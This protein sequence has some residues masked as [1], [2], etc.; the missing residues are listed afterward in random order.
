[1]SSINLVHAFLTAILVTKQK[2]MR[3]ASRCLSWLAHNISESAGG[4]ESCG[5]FVEG[6][7]GSSR[8]TVTPALVIADAAWGLRL[9]CV[10]PVIAG[11]DT[12]YLRTG[13][14]G[15]CRSMFGRMMY[16]SNCSKEREL[17]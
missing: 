13:F 3:T 17:S 6:T 9:C 8:S 16:K 2:A 4:G 5:I 7:G 10:A 12:F 15:K 1:M 14:R 11:I